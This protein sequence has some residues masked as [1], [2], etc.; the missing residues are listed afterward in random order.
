M[1]NI[2]CLTPPH[3]K[4]KL[5]KN[6]KTLSSPGP[7]PLDPRVGWP[8]PNNKR[9]RSHSPGH[10]PT[11]SVREDSLL[12]RV[13]V[14][15]HGLCTLCPRCTPRYTEVHPGT[16]R[17]PRWGH[18]YVVSLYHF[19]TVQYSTVQYSTV[20]YRVLT[21]TVSLYHCITSLQYSTV[22]YSTV[23][24]STVQVY[25]RYRY[26][27]VQYST[28]PRVHCTAYTVHCTREKSHAKITR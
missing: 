2:K 18:D 17:C 13:S 20:Q 28:G 26:S 4:I 14:Y 21:F 11:L 25:Y 9:L 8:W 23:Q 27:T 7:W 16:P 19:I 6:V 10:R 15:R 24:Y 12:L 3:E 22:Q 1:L 5:I